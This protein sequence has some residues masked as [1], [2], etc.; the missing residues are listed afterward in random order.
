VSH[1]FIAFGELLDLYKKIAELG[2]FTQRV[3]ELV[4]VLEDGAARA[5]RARSSAQGAGQTPGMSGEESGAHVIRMESTTVATPEGSVLARGLCLSLAPHG[6]N[7]LI[8]GP[9]GTGKTSI[10]RMLCGLWP[11]L[12]GSFTAGLPRGLVYVGQRP[13]LCVG[14]LR[15][16][17][18]YPYRAESAAVL[19]IAQARHGCVAPVS[20]SSVDE[21]LCRL[22]ELVGLAPL[23]ERTIP[24]QMYFL[25]EMRT[26]SGIET[27]IVGLQ[28]PMKAQVAGRRKQP[29]KRPF[30]WESSSGSA[31]RACERRYRQAPATRNRTVQVIGLPHIIM[32]LSYHRIV[33]SSYC[34]T[35]D[36]CRLASS[37]ARHLRS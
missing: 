30:R 31:W 19:E 25:L 16:Q 33:I 4:R 3:D 29:G 1:S 28:V 21:V 20:I 24:V 32:M 7:L 36:W 2:G 6:G 14:T 13:Y 15:D 26:A 23:L 10:C 27:T 5:T 35:P 9:N 12:E 37:A 8:T 17:L 22:L 11:A 34:L 18:T